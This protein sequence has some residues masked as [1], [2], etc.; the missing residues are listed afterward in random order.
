MKW[1]RILALFDRPLRK[2]TIVAERYKIESVIGM[3]SYGVTYVVNDLQINRYKVLKQLRQSKQRYE[4]DRKSFE[5]EKM[6]LRSFRMGEKKLFC[7][8][9]YAWKKFRRLYFLGWACIY[10]T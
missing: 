10:R 8:G 7:D 3:G 1:R 4:T 2:N 5:Q 6:I 9:I